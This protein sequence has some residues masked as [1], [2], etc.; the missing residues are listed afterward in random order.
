MPDGLWQ[1]WLEFL[2]TDGGTALR[3][4]AKRRNRTGRDTE[5]WATGLTQVYLEGALQRA[6]EARDVTRRCQLRSA[7][8]PHDLGRRHDLPRVPLR[9]LGGVE[10]QADHRRRQRRAADRA[11][12]EH[13]RRRRVP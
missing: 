3:R 8:D 7:I 2:P 1:G 5:Y 12:V 10:D 9:M 4:G 11:G 6:L 13:G